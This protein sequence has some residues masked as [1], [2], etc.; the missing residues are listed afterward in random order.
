M[1][2]AVSL[3]PSTPFPKTTNIF[4]KPRTGYSVGNPW[5]WVDF[6][7]QNSGKVLFGV[8]LQLHHHIV[9]S[10]YLSYNPPRNGIQ[11]L[12]HLWHP[13][14]FHTNQDIRIYRHRV[15]LPSS[16]SIFW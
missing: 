4:N 16:L 7:T 10:N 13:F 8:C 5:N 9:G 1:L 12:K 14:R 2:E 3:A 11:S 6:V 15:P